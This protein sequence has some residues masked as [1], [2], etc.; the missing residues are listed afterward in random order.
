MV[1]EGY[2]SQFTCV[3]MALIANLHEEWS[4]NKKPYH[5]SNSWWEPWSMLW[6]FLVRIKWKNVMMNVRFILMPEVINIFHNFQLCISNIIYDISTR[7]YVTWKLKWMPMNSLQYLKIGL[8]CCG[9][10]FHFSFFHSLSVPAFLIFGL[11]FEFSVDYP[12]HSLFFPLY[13][14]IMAC[15]FEFESYKSDILRKLL[16]TYMPKCYLQEFHTTI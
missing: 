2:K 14:L 4:L 12:F 16:V 6:M 7:V 11:N 8:L 5:W 15:V 10:D 3:Q 9:W 1:L 13:M